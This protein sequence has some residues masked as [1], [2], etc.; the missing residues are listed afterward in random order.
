VAQEL[1]SAEPVTS[2]LLSGLVYQNSEILVQKL[3]NVKAAGPL[4][5]GL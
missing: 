1:D 4:P 3:L 2:L 5:G